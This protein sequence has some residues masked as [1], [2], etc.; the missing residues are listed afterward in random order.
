MWAVVRKQFALMVLTGVVLV[1]C[2]VVAS[3]V[4]GAFHVPVW[5]IGAPLLGVSMLSW[6]K[7]DPNRFR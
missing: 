5:V 7:L 3:L 6:A 1:A 4:A 2:W